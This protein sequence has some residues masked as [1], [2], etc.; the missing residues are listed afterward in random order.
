[1][2][3]KEIFLTEKESFSDSDSLNSFGWLKQ[4]QHHQ[5]ANKSFFLLQKFCLQLIS[6]TPR[7]KHKVN[8]PT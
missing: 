3:F 8:G 1:L 2:S 7:Q 4:H 5:L 6:S